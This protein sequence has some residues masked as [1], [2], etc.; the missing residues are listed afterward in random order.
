[1]SERFKDKNYILYDF[2]HELHLVCPKCNQKLISKNNLETYLSE[3][4]CTNCSYRA[5]S[6][7]IIIEIS[8]NAN[9]NNC[10]HKI[11][12]SKIVNKKKEQVILRCDSCSEVHKFE[13][14]VSEY[15]S[16]K[17]LTDKYELWYSENY[18]GNYF[19]AYNT[20]HLN[21]IESYIK[22][23]L[24]ER[25]KRT[26][27][28]LVERLPKFIKSAKNRESLLKMIKKIKLK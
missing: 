18:K 21:Y 13:P 9:C 1:M 7:N 19:W 17:Q 3:L 24:R 2:L 22:A 16:F 20:E 26:H 28:T 10:G 5:I 6:D 27:V 11:K 4:S 12:I 25:N 8:V 23:D 14:K 15:K